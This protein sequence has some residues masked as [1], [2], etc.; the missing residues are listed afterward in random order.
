ML[1]QW[2]PLI[3]LFWGCGPWT[4]FSQRL[5]NQIWNPSSLSSSFAAQT[6]YCSDLLLFVP[7]KE[8]Q[9]LLFLLA[10]VAGQQQYQI[11]R[12][13]SQLYL[14]S[15]LLAFIHQMENWADAIPWDLQDQGA[16]RVSQQ[17]HFWTLSGRKSG[18]ICRL[19]RTGS[20][21]CTLM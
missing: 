2:Y 17:R 10:A 8:L 21:C 13:I 19:T 16:L 6:S 5:P 15:L 12:S 4:I 14:D 7:Q 20:A 3:S 18:D 11:Y 1:L 9:R